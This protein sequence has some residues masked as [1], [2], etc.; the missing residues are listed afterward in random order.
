MLPSVCRRSFSGGTRSHWCSFVAERLASLRC[1]PFGRG[2]TPSSRFVKI[3]RRKNVSDSEHQGEPPQ[4]ESTNA[5]ARS[6]LHLL[7]TLT[8]VHICVIPASFNQFGVGSGFYDLA[9]VE[10]DNLIEGE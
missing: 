4:A 10:D 5:T 2:S 3:P 1:T 6:T 8:L 7:Q 9:F